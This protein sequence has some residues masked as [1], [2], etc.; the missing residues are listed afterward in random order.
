MFF[1]EDDYYVQTFTGCSL[2][3]ETVGAKTFEDCIFENC[4]FLECS[5][6][7]SRFIDCQFLGCIISIA[8]LSGCR[9]I[10]PVFNKCKVMGI[11]WTK[12]TLL[13]DPEFHNC[14]IDLSNFRMLEIP[15]TRIINCEAKEADFAETDFTDAVLTGTNFEDS[16]FFKTNLSKA[17]LRGASNFNIDITN[18]TIKN[19][20]FSYPEAVSLLNSLDI[21]IE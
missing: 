12:T 20:K 14:Q 19:A 4:H 13:Q 6:E 1:Q 8:N 18:N 16:L 3:G 2:N 10:H 5:F 11:D 15:K 7:K 17:D 21:I 9:F